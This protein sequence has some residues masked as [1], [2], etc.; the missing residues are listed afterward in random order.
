MSER[1]HVAEIDG[2]LHYLPVG[3]G[4]LSP[5]AVSADGST[6][7]GEAQAT[8]VWRHAYRYRNG[9]AE[10]LAPLP[11]S[12]RAQAHAVSADG[13]IVVGIDRADV[14]AQ[15]QPVLWDDQGNITVL[16]LP[17]GASYGR[18]HGVSADG[19]VVVGKAGNWGTIWR[20]G[21][22]AHT[23]QPGTTARAVSA[24]GAIVVGSLYLEEEEDWVAA[25]WDEANGTRRLDDLLIELGVDVSGWTLDLSHVISGDGR[26]VLGWATH[27]S[28]ER[29]NFMVTVPEGQGAL[30]PEPLWAT[31]IAAPEPE[32]TPLLAAALV[33]LVALRRSRRAGLS[34]VCSATERAR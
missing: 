28:G 14:D 3:S 17:P 34:T 25:I 19:S 26:T 18:P 8:P 1:H 33:A 29:A 20:N 27:D 4:S 32:S 12:L 30:D 15:Q 7:V 5:W 13:S 31:P 6:I 9:V 22:V 11:G 21:L 2:V 16:Q 10:V 23:M 24:N